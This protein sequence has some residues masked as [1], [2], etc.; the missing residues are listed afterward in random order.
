MTPNC[1][2][3]AGGPG[4]GC[5]GRDGRALPGFSC[6]TRIAQ[7]TGA[8][9]VHLAEIITTKGTSYR[10]RHTSI[11]TLPSVTETGPAD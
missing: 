5:C 11:E 9:G 6:R 7:G 2:P 3:K 4:G 10:I 8:D 1:F